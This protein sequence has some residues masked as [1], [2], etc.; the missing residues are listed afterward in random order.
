MLNELLTWV[1]LLVGLVFV[2][3]KRRGCGAL[4]LAYFMILSLG[5]VPGVLAYLESDPL[6]LVLGSAEWTKIGFD[7]TLIGMSAF[8]VGTIAARIL[9]QLTMSV[10]A[11]QQSISF[12]TFS[13]VAWRTFMIAAV[14]H[15]ALFRVVAFVPSLTAIASASGGLLILS[16]WFWLYLSVVAKN[17]QRTLLILALLPLLPL[18]T[19]VTGGFIGFGTA[20]ALTIVMFYFCIARRRFWFYVA[21]PAVVFLGLSL[22]VTYSQQRDDIREVVWYQNA[23]ALERLDQISKLVTDF[24]FLDLSNQLHLKALDTRLNQNMLVGKAVMLHREGVSELQY[25]ATVPI[26]ALIP[27]AVWPDKPGVA[28]S[29]DWVTR[30]TGISFAEGTSVGIGN[31]L[32]FYMNFGM[33]GV[34]AGFAVLGFILMRL[35]QAV[36]RALAMRNIP[37]AVQMSLPGVAMLQPMGSVEE[38]LVTLIAAIVASQALIRLKLLAPTQRPTTKTSARKTRAIGLR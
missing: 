32:E 17:T 35:D 19:L 14:A 29:Q 10:K 20:W 36:M 26:W 37:S 28:G 13:R 1:A 25:G 5:H 6:F 9:P 38:M 27:R 3:D 23:G 18:F 4:T 15:F 7:V 21:A 12:Q 16:A 33:P 34:L 24:Q 2:L 8:I 30:F 22:F 31:V 11:Y